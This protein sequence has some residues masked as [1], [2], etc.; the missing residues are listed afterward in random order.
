VFCGDYN[1]Y[2]THFDNLPFAF[3]RIE[4][5]KEERAIKGKTSIPDIEG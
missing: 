3:G 5:G 1:K 4:K 2:P